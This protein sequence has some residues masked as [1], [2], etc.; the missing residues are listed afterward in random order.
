MKKI[1]LR[2]VFI[3]I[4]LCI[5]VFTTDY[6]RV[7]SN[8]KP[9]FAIST[10]SADD[11]G[12][13]KYQGLFYSVDIRYKDLEINNIEMNLFGNIVAKSNSYDSLPQE[14]LNSTQSFLE[15]EKNRLNENNHN[16]GY[17]EYKIQDLE[18]IQSYDLWLVQ[19]L[20]REIEP[21]KNEKT[22]YSLYKVNYLMHSKTPENI[23]LA[24]PTEILEDNWVLTTYPDA[25]FL[26]FN[27]ETNEYIGSKMINDLELYSKKFN[28]EIIR[29]LHNL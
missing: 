4:I 15:K 26:I 10:N 17:D 24:G 28:Q 13:G 1:I 11:G 5:S 21:S 6:I 20:E 22:I 18:Y 23:I 12:S 7:K 25:T 2:A 14:I 3:V 27:S 16:A 8:Q 29:Y 9:I 19:N